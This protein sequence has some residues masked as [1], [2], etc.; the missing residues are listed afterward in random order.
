MSYLRSLFSLE[1]KVAI[2][3]GGTGVLGSVMC[4][5]LA[6]A[7][8]KVALIGRRKEVADA[9]AQE[10]KKSGGDARPSVMSL[11]RG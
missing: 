5:A 3:T 10:I 9:L 2:V 4:K 8:A 6:N 7:G 1:G 11:M